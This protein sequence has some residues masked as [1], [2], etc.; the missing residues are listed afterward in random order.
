MPWL[1]LTLE[2][3]M[4][5]SETLSDALMQLGALSVELQ[6]AC[7]G[8]PGERPLFAEPGWDAAAAWDATRI[9]SLFEPGADLPGIISAAAQAAGLAEPPAWRVEALEDQDWVRATQAQFPP[10]RVSARLWIVPTWHEPPD[11]NAVNLIL[12]P[13]LA[14][15]TGSHPSTRLCLRWLD[16]II[17]GG[18]HVLDYG[19]GSGILAIAALKLG[20]GRALGV[21]IDPQAVKASRANA[22]CNRVIAQFCLPG[23]APPMTADVVVANILARPLQVLAPVL[24]RAT[25]MGGKIGLSGILR[26]QAQDVTACYSQWFSMDEPREEEGWVLLA[27]TR[28]GSG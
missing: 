24:A 1:A 21:D 10:V 4:C 27:G 6:D 2:V 7:A 19:C 5:H 28:G 8:G 22:G 20:A 12:D 13:G 14:F 26:D 16:S 9:I 25:R 3:P 23:E 17:R 15:G 11:A 18:E